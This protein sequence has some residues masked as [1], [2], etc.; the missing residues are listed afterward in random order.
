M[1]DF[2]DTYHFLFTGKHRYYVRKGSRQRGCAVECH[3]RVP[4][5]R[6]PERA[7]CCPFFKY[8]EHSA[9]GETVPS[10]APGTRLRLRA[11]CSGYSVGRRSPLEPAT[12]KGSPGVE[13]STALLSTVMGAKFEFRRA[14]E[15][16]NAARF[17]NTAKPV[18]WGSRGAEL[19]SSSSSLEPLRFA[20]FHSHG[21]SH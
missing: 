12:R 5:F 2:R 17:A 7:K 14:S 3:R 13:F 9:V 15:G 1:D 21:L 19:D 6:V 11:R 20:L 4:F 16:G 10:A 8:G 18:L